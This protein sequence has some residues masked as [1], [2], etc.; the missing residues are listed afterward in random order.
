MFENKI[1]RRVQPLTFKFMVNHF[2]VNYG[3][4][5]NRPFGS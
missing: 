5:I 2:S 3:S 1:S 4:I